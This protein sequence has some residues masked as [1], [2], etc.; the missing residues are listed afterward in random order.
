MYLTYLGHRLNRW[1]YT[2]SIGEAVLGRGGG[3]GW[4]GPPQIIELNKETPEIAPPL[5]GC[6][7]VWCGK[8][9]M[10]ALNAEGWFI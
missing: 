8:N 6:I 1:G 2:G 9:P 5:K 3:Y 7:W 10:K 4:F